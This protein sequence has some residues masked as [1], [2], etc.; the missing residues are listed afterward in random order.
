MTFDI[1]FF[2]SL[3]PCRVIRVLSLATLF[4]REKSDIA[5]PVTPVFDSGFLYCIYS[6][7]G[8]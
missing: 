3:I 7:P 5:L 4:Y 6:S 8:D 1:Q 2:R